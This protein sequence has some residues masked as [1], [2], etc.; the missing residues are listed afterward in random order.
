[1]YNLCPN[2]KETK[3]KETVWPIERENNPVCEWNDNKEI[4]AGSFPYLFLRGYNIL[5]QS[6]FGR[7]FIKHLFL[8]YDGRFE[9]CTPFV[10]LLFNQM[11]RHAAIRKI[12]RVETSNRNILN[13][14]ESLMKSETFKKE[15]EY[16][17]NNP[18][19][20]KSKQLN[21]KIMRIL[22]VFGNA[23][24]F[25]PF[26]RAQTRPKIHAMKIKYEGQ[27]HFV[28]IAPP[29]HDDLMLLKINE[30]ITN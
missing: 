24:S 9:K 3:S 12:A 16:A 25:S 13:K 15:L 30:I 29:E 21:S 6:T 27:S 1:M 26:E 20:N 28:T 4:V 17:I 18:K 7:R 8:Y 14:I 5:P 10:N 2:T 22:G 19:E 23:V 11:Q